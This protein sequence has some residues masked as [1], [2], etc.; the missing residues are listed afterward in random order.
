MVTIPA[1][2][3]DIENGLQL[4]NNLLAWDETKPRDS[5]N[6]PRIFFSDRCQN[7]IFA[8]GEYTAKLGP[9]EATKDAVDVLRYLAVSNPDFFDEK[10]NPPVTTGGY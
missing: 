3:V 5:M 9:G 4:L 2:G 7:I 6:S 1:S 10:T 8:M